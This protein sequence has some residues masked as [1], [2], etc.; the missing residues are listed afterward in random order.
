MKRSAL[1]SIMI[2]CAFTSPVLALG[3]CDSAPAGGSGGSASLGS[4]GVSGDAI[5]GLDSDFRSRLSQMMADANAQMGGNMSIYSGYRSPER[6]AELYAEALEKYGSEAE[7][8]RW[9]APPG[10]SNH[11]RGLAVD[12]AWNGKT[13]HYGSA[14]S[15]WLS[16]NLAKY[17]LTR[18]LS[19]EGWHIEPI[20]ARGGDAGSGS[21]P[22]YESSESCISD[23]VQDLPEIFLMP[24]ESAYP[25]APLMPGTY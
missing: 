16:S 25:V 20:G 12:M 24:W 21:A 13:I 14:I 11:G 10:R 15:D 23:T 8:R 17:G 18:P 2:F 5:S 6:Q 19:N 9:V 4:S 22:V 3:E 1:L 7:A